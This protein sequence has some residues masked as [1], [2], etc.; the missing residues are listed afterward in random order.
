MKSEV[1][2][3]E[4]KRLRRCYEIIHLI[5]AF[6]SAPVVKYLPPFMIEV[7]K[8]DARLVGWILGTGSLVS[9]MGGFIG[10]RVH[11]AVQNKRF[12]A[13][14]LQVIQVFPT[15]MMV[16]TAFFWHDSF[17]DAW[18]WYSKVVIFSLFHFISC[19][20]G[21]MYRIFITA[22]VISDRISWGPVRAMVSVGWGL[23]TWT[24]GFFSDVMGVSS[25]LFTK[26]Y[27]NVVNFIFMMFAFTNRKQ[28]R[29]SMLDPLISS[30][31]G[32]PIVEQDQWSLKETIANCLSTKYRVINVAN[33]I[34]MGVFQAFVD[35]F[36]YVY[37]VHRYKVSNAFLG[38]LTIVMTL[39]ETPVF[40]YGTE[41]I[42]FLG[43]H[44]LYILSHLCYVI[45]VL[46][47]P[48]LPAD[49]LW[50][51]YIIEFSHAFTF[52]GMW[53]ASVEFGVDIGGISNAGIVQAVIRA[54]YF[55]TGTLIGSILCPYI[56]TVFGW[57]AMW[58][59]CSVVVGTWSLLYNIIYYC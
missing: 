1:D 47:Y 53:V 36:L 28:E 44:G 18:P 16:M 50:V 54:I 24:G 30:S 10:G 6:A 35:Q 41:L 23:G 55:N 33:L 48:I 57:D 2:V 34:I 52:A 43:L 5:D 7:L 39:M 3:P 8:I 26:I 9:A 21:N 46:M 11:D 19:I 59:F 31:S 29:L 4:T 13:T 27:A 14:L 32:E 15:V 40:F 22:C 56:F 20:C 58:R 37:L 38:S 42:Q 25:F 51:L 49:H 17:W 45:R 12:L